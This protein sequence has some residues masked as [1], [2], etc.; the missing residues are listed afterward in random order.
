MPFFEVWAIFPKN[1]LP[2]PDGSFK[3]CNLRGK[4][5]S[6]RS[7]GSLARRL[8][9]LRIEGETIPPAKA[10]LIGKEGQ[11]VGVLTSVCRSMAL[12]CVIGM[13]YVKTASSEDGTP[14]QVQRPDG[15]P[16]DAAIVP[17]PFTNPSDG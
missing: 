14:L 5:T 11:P 7:R 13:G 3:A 9:G 1:G 6:S 4:E 17:L 16:V 12:S 2:K 15:Q 10:A 8:C